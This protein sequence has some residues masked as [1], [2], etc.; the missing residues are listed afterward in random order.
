[1]TISK[2]KR[3]SP[4]VPVSVLSALFFLLATSFA[5][6]AEYRVVFRNLDLLK[7]ERVVGFDLTFKTASISAM[8]RVPAGWHIELE[9]DPSGIVKLKGGIIVG[10][11]ALSEKDLQRLIKIRSTGSRADAPDLHGD[12]VVTSDFAHERHLLIDSKKY[13]LLKADIHRQP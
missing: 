1:M 7:S 8:N 2:N 12:I 9:N 11:A 13:R 4:K 5:W 10:A 6:S 3:V